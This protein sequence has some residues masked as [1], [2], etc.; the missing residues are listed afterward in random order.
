MRSAFRKLPLMVLGLALMAIAQPASAGFMTQ[1][2]NYSGG[3]PPFVDNL[4]FQKF[5]TSLGTLTA[6]TIEL[7]EAGTVTSEVV[8]FSGVITPPVTASWVGAT[9]SATVTATGP[10]NTVSSDTLTTTPF[11]GTSTGFSVTDGPPLT[12]SVSATTNATNLALYEGSGTGTYTV[13]AS[14]SALSSSGTSASPF[15]T[16]GG[17]ANIDGSVTIDYYYTAAVPEP[18][19]LGMVVLGLGGIYVVRRFR[20]KGA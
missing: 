17:T 5:N 2:L 19:S 13:T 10:D 9:T 7:T 4:T 12:A 16:F 20:R 1:T 11:S 14:A 18:A 6:V 3:E 15:I 8:N